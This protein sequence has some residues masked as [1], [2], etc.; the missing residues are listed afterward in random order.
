MLRNDAINNFST[1]RDALISKPIGSPALLTDQVPLPIKNG[2]KWWEYNLGLTDLSGTR[3]NKQH[4]N[5]SLP[6]TNPNP[7]TLFLNF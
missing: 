1:I 4:R 7:K 3:C 2:N 6:P 5:N